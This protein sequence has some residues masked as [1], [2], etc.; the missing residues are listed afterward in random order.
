M[1]CVVT[2]GVGEDVAPQRGG[3]SLATVRERAWVSVTQT[4][5][6]LLS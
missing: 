4:N 1:W 5:N 6:T 2:D 3:A